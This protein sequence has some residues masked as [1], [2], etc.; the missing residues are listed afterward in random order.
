MF[1]PTADKDLI[2]RGIRTPAATLYSTGLGRVDSMAVGLLVMYQAS[3][4]SKL[5]GLGLVPLAI[6]A[7]GIYKNIFPRQNS[8]YHGDA[9]SEESPD[10]E[11]N[12]V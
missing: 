8:L 1:K 9:D 2:R 12:S 10:P 6:I 4:N 11:R 3:R 7:Y 5:S